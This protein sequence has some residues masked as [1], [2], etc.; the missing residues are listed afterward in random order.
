MSS[1]QD[2]E[3]ALRV[4]VKTSTGYADS[5]VIWAD[6]TARRPEG[7]FI[8]LK[9]TDVISFTGPDELL[10]LQDLSRVGEEIEAQVMG[11]REFGVSLQAFSSAVCSPGSLV[12]P[13]PL[14][15]SDATARAALARCQLGLSLPSVRDTLAAEGATP[16]DIGSVQNLTALVGT[17]FEGRALLEVRFYCTMTI[18]E[19]TTYIEHVNTTDYIGPPNGTWD[20]IDI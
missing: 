1:W 7:D 20:G 14:G 11:R 12:N 8:T 13:F 9:L 3:D 10:Q 18:S 16:F 17:K 15:F 2:I 4:W 6:Q 19:F 5:Q